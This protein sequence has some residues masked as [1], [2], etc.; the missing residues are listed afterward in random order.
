[1]TNTML[2]GIG[3]HAKRIYLPFIKKCSKN[4]GINL[5]VGIECKG[6]KKRTYE[7]LN[8][9]SIHIPLVL[10]VDPFTPEMSIDLKNKLNEIVKQNRISAVIIATEP[11]AHKA[12]AIWALKNNLHIL[13]DKPITTRQNAVSN[14]EQ[15]KG[16]Y[17]DFT[18]IN[19]AAKKSTSIF[20]VNSQRRYHPGKQKVYKLIS[21]IAS[22][23]NMPVTSIHSSDSDGQW[24]FPEEIIREEYH[25]YNRGNG[26]CSHS[27]YHY[28]D[29]I[30]NFYKAGI[31]EA[32]KAESV[33]VYTSFLTPRGFFQ[34]ISQKDYQ[35]WFGDKYKQIYTDNELFRK[36][37]NFGEID[38]FSLIR[39]LKNNETICNI[40]LDLMHN[41]FCRRSW[42]EANKDLY[43]QNGRVKHEHH[44]IQQ[45]PLQSIQ[46]HGYQ[47]NSNHDSNEETD[48]DLGGNNHYE[49]NVF[50]NS[51]IIG[52]ESMIRY[53]TRSFDSDRLEI[54]KN[55]P[56]NQLT[57]EYSRELAI[58]EFFNLING[59]IKE[60]LSPISDHEIPV[61][62][63]SS[64]YIAKIN[65]QP[66]EFR[67]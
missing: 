45:G 47:L 23:Y 25:G 48:F 35:S 49:I 12:Y 20:I 29:T 41:S 59:K 46:I 15:A 11:T 16:I 21:E 52:G 30:Y 7:Y 17:R 19:N 42:V 33:E 9:L 8:Q 62:I 53:S 55:I 57:Y 28:F 10:F 13:M 24:F 4:F 18:D 38:S 2:I 3:P 37:N 44:L 26:K 61:K 5:C 43:K 65:H 27:G 6:Q 54:D 51:G 22:K 64:I 56:I 31:I 1:M 32:K 39:L 63:M 34:Q 60:S 58:A 40:S 36:V 50:R 66:V 67:L 14:I